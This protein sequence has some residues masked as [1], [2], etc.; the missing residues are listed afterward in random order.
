[1]TRSNLYMFSYGCS[2]PQI[3]SMLVW[4]LIECTEQNPQTWRAGCLY[5]KSKWELQS[6]KRLRECSAQKW[7]VEWFSTSSQCSRKEGLPEK[8][9]FKET[10]S[11]WGSEQRII[12]RG[13]FQTDTSEQE[14]AHGARSREEAPSLERKSKHLYS[15]ITRIL[16]SCMY[17]VLK[18]PKEIYF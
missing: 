18:N 15:W 5:R 13:T 17:K 16:G 8:L 12:W 7:G 9:T 10:L 4:Q 11:G 1:M 14:V 6:K 3:F 2:F